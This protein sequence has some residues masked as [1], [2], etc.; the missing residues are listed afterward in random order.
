[1]ARAASCC[2]WRVPER[3]SSAGG[4]FSSVDVRLVPGGVEHIDFFGGEA[5]AKLPDERGRVGVIG[6]KDAR[7]DLA[8]SVSDFEGASRFT[9]PRFVDEPRLDF[10]CGRLSVEAGDQVEGSLLL[11]IN[12]TGILQ[13]NR[14]FHTVCDRLHGSGR[15][16]PIALHCRLQ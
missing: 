2:S 15:A 12:P 9:E 1:M 11:S 6:G 3:S 13:E 10:A 5:L 4:G 14:D 8:I 7:H 16:H